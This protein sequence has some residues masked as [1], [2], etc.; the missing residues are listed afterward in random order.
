MV[1]LC[2]NILARLREFFLDDDDSSSNLEVL[3]QTELSS[4]E[5]QSDMIPLRRRA[6]ASPPGDRCVH[7][8]LEAEKRGN[9]K[10]QQ[11]RIRRINL[12][13]KAR[14]EAEVEIA[15][16]RKVGFTFVTYFIFVTSKSTF[17]DS[18]III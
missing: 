12:I 1:K 8:L 18:K 17:S 4:E 9:E 14:A 2:G 3:N 5:Q 13:K 11:A 7:L 15:D 6:A 10:V 16:I